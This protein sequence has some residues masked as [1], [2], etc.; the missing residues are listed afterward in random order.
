MNTVRMTRRR[1]LRTGS[2]VAA[3]VP[4]S[5][6]FEVRETDT[7]NEGDDEPDPALEINGRFLSSA[8]PIELVEPDFEQTTGFGGDARLTYVHWHGEENS[9]WHQSPLE[10]AVGETLS[11]RTRFLEEGAEAVPIGRGE[12]FFQEVHATAE[13]PTDLVTTTVDGAVVDI[14]A[15]SSGDGEI[16]FELWTGEDRRWR[17]PPLPIEI[18]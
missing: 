16:V 8:F 14:E 15:G 11:G 10:I 3:T 9:H 1:L 18:V 4:V 12:A 2:A 13:T 5:G 17:S 7:P 6:C